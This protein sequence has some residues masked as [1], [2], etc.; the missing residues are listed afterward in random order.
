MA[1]DLIIGLQWGDEGKGKIVDILAPKYKIITRFNGGPNAGHTILFDG[2]KFVLHVVPSGIHRTSCMNYIGNGVVLNPVLLCEEIKNLEQAGINVKEHLF[3]SNKAHI[4]IPTHCAIDKASEESKGSKKIGSTNKGI[5][6]TYKDKVG[7]DG[8]RM[9]DVFSD[10]FKEKYQN[11]K[12]YHMEILQDLYK[13]HFEIASIVDEEEKFF[14]AIEILKTYKICDTVELINKEISKG[15]NILAEGAQGSMLD[16]D[17]GTYPFV[18]SSSV[19]AGGVCTGLG[20]SPKSINK[21]YGAF[22][23]YVTRVGSGP[24]P[25]E[26]FDETGETMRKI[27]NEFGST[28]GR[29][30]RCGWLDLIA[31]KYTCTM[32]GVTD[33]VILKS[34]VLDAF[35]KIEVCVGYLDENNKKL[36]WPPIDM[37]L[38]KPIYK[39]FDGW[40]TDT[41]KIRKFEDLPKKMIEY[42]DFISNFIDIPISFISIGPDR[43]QTIVV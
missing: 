23:A 37:S 27:G 40:K 4:I 38:V 30:R 34:D 11:L 17:H 25:T 32:S 39:S 41:T 35:D 3:I 13:E 16:I 22:K 1:I 10:S 14:E 18:T 43:E 12:G 9:V 26:L 24:F 20:V 21:I 36:D 42:L 19:I 2:K 7:R 15:S 29:P 5:G 8:L 31:L 33:L 6:P 28:T